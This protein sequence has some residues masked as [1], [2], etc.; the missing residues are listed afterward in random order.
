MIFQRGPTPVNLPGEGAAAK[1]QNSRL[2]RSDRRSRSENRRLH[3]EDDQ[4][5]VPG[6]HRNNDRSSA[7]HRR[8]LRQVFYFH[9]LINQ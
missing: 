1:E 6:K 8:R 5:S 2:G 9:V 7:E 4:G 3:P